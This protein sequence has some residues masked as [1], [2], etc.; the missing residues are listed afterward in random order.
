MSDKAKGMT[1]YPETK[2]LSLEQLQQQMH[3]QQLPIENL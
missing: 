2:Q 3:V 1:G